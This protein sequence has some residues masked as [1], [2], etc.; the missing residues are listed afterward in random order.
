MT[1]LFKEY[2]KSKDTEYIVI[3]PDMSICSCGIELSLKIK[4][5][6]GIL[7][8]NVPLRCHIFTAVC[9][10]ENCTNYNQTIHFNGETY[11]Y[12]NYNDKLIFPIEMVRS[13]MDNYAVSGV[14][15][16]S[17]INCYYTRS[18]NMG[19]DTIFVPV[20]ELDGFIGLLHRLMC[21]ATEFIVFSNPPCCL[22]PKHICMDGI[23]IS[24]P[25]NR[26]PLFDFLFELLTVNYRSTTRNDR[27]LPKLTK[28][29]NDEVKKCIERKLKVPH[30]W[31][32]AKNIS[33]NCLFYCKDEQGY[34]KNSAKRFA[35]CTM[36]DISPAPLLL[37]EKI[38]NL[39]LT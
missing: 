1:Q 30:D 22:M 18:M 10:N 11:G 9:E 8:V 4:R 21:E 7:L 27:Q 28:N 31:K 12:F 32:T 5:T 13:F 3:C 29:E 39:L 23:V 2:P 6:N 34:L 33:L 19:S 17:W 37:D 20:L 38:E 15:F 35:E 26:M 36:A 24:I 25:F 14:G 16:K